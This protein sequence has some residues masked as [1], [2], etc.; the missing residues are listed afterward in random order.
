MNQKNH[1]H[2]RNPSKPKCKKPVC[3]Q[4][5]QMCDKDYSAK[6]LAKHKRL[7]QSQTAFISSKKFKGPKGFQL[8][9]A[10]GMTFGKKSEF[11]NIQKKENE[12]VDN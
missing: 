10:P 5:K 2:V 6:M 4:G 3:A 7:V 1:L 12:K 11:I 8:L 9:D